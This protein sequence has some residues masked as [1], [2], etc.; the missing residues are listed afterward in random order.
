[1]RDFDIAKYLKEHQL[2]SYGILNH[3]VDLKPLKEETS[4]SD[5][6][7]AA[8]I[9]GNSNKD[10]I[11]R[12]KKL[13][14]SDKEI[15][16]QLEK[17]REDVTPEEISEIPYKGNGKNLTG[18]GGGDEFE[19]AE[20]ISEEEIDRSRIEGLVDQRQLAKFGEAVMAIAQDLDDEGF[21][22]VDIKKLLIDKLNGMIIA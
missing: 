5:L 20:T 8:K 4:D 10:I 9:A 13:G 21:D 17:L 3:Y 15:I 1:M 18:N 16:A 7:K 22:A 14:Y 19:Q 2:G 6:D 11:A 12:L